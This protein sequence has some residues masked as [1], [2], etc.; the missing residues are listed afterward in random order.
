MKDFYY[1]IPV[2]AELLG[3]SSVWIWHLIKRGKLRSITIITSG[4]KRMYFA[5]SR[6]SLKKFKERMNNY[7]L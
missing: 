3:Y 4:R 6:K 1:T 5:V 7:A 2:C